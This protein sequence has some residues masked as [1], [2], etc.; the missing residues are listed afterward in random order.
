MANDDDD[1]D[2][3]IKAAAAAAAEFSEFWR[4]VINY[5]CT[6][7]VIYYIYTYTFVYA[8]GC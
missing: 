7:K 4:L 3:L 2:E 5:Y 8:Q 1:D 6:H